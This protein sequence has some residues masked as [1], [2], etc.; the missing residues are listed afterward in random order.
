[1]SVQSSTLQPDRGGSPALPASS[2]R[3]RLGLQGEWRDGA[4]IGLQDFSPN[5]HRTGLADGCVPATTTLFFFFFFF[6]LTF[7]ES[8][9]GVA[10]TLPSAALARTSKE[11]LPRWTT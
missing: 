1:M 2:S 10:S 3:G 9:A 7:Q 6:F 8:L 5:F 11:C 4:P